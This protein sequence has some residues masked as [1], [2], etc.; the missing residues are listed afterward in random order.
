MKT[1]ITFW[2]G[3]DTIGGNIAE[4]KY[5]N[6][7]IIFDF[8]LVYNPASSM[9]DTTVKRKHTH[10]LDLL[11]LHA[12]PAIDGIYSEK[13]LS[14]AHSFAM[15]K[16]L[17]Q[18]QTDYQ[19]G[20]FISH[21]HL[22]H[23]GAMDT[24]A[25]AIP[26]YMT[27]A[28]R[29]LFRALEQIDE[30][31]TLDRAYESLAYHEKITIGQITV[32]PY[33][34]D[35]DVIG[36]TSFLIET[37]D[38]TILYSGDIRMHGAH[39][40]YM[41]AWLDIMKEKEISMLLIE[42]TSFRPEESGLILTEKQAD[43]HSVPEA[44]KPQ[45][46]IPRLQSETDIEQVAVTLMKESHGLALFNVYHRNVE[47]I[48]QFLNAAKIV[49]RIAVL[50]PETAY[51]VNEFLSTGEFRI[52]LEEDEALTPLQKNLL[53][54][55]EGITVEQI[56]ERPEKYFLQNS[57]H[58]IYRLLDLNLKDSNYLHANGMPLGPYDP[59]YHTM[60]AILTHFQ[61]DYESL[62][63]SGHASK[64]DI[65]YVIDQIKPR[66]VI[67]WHS[68]HPELVKPINE[69]V[70]VLLPEKFRTYEL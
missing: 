39:Q 17:A 23:M 47:R 34:V 46:K 55:Y 11:K 65:L 24:I 8:G 5:G 2:G 20:V 19:T 63:V 59:S 3:L 29:Q 67:P 51:L 62:D 33:Q 42:G 44:G 58:H 40:E 27:E 15:E 31:L 43:L 70:E 50:E 68:K 6:D 61:V 48:Q 1:T 66:L 49:G 53:N 64:E 18:E 35:H 21:L 56:N 41:D 16:P 57:F 12:I 14:A 4:V 32:T 25:P 52:F 7:R 69:N 54:Q 36:A 22:D 37:P 60:H 30:G 13:D 28:S 9:L 45:Q 38:E 26:V 10:V